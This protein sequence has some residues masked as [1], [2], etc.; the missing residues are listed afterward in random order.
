MICAPLLQ[1]NANSMWSGAT[2]NSFIRTDTGI[3]E[4]W[5]CVLVLALQVFYVGHHIL[6]PSLHRP[7]CQKG[8]DDCSSETFNWEGWKLEAETAQ[9]ER[10]HANDK[11][12]L[13]G[14]QS[15]SVVEAFL[16]IVCQQFWM[17][18]QEVWD[19]MMRLPQCHRA[20]CTIFRILE[21][22]LR[23][24]QLRLDVRIGFCLLPCSAYTWYFKLWILFLQICYL[25]AI[26]FNCHELILACSDQF[27]CWLCNT[28]NL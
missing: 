10:C 27:P 6:F 11:R 16:G 28:G 12:V 25:R 4:H 8:S 21:L 15:C 19:Y 17:M 22:Q 13:V 7:L 3:S 5:D 20:S 24:L 18:E 23:A 9:K 26:F 2:K 1:Q 14:L